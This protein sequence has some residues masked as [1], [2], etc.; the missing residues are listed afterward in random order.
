M[1]Y[2]IKLFFATA[3]IAVTSIT[4]QG[5]I[6]QD[7]SVFEINKMEPRATAIPYPDKKS[8]IANNPEKNSSYRSLNGEWKFSWYESVYDAPED[9][10]T[11]NYND[12]KWGHI[13]VPGNWEVNGYG[14]PIYVNQPYAFTS[15][16]KPPHI[17]DSINNTGLYREWIDIPDEWN[18]KTVILHIGAVKS[19]AFI[20]I[21]GTEV[22]YTQGAK[23]PSEFDIT[24]YIKPGKNLLAM[25]V[26]RWSDGSYLECQDFWR[27]SGIQR[28]VYLTAHNEIF[29]KDFHV[30][31]VLDEALSKSTIHLTVETETTEKYE[32]ITA[33]YQLLDEK[34]ATV[35]EKEIEITKDSITSSIS[36]DNPKLWSAEKPNL[37][38]SVI[39]LKKRNKILESVACNTGFRDVRIENG[40]LLV[41]R[42]PVYLKGV[43]RHEHDPV[44]AHY[45]SK[46]SMLVDIQLMKNHNINA[47][48]TC[49]Y[50]DDPY[51]YE[52][53]DKYG[54]YLIDEANIESHGMGYHPDRTLGNN[55][56]WEAAHMMRIRRMVER[57]KNHPSI[58]IWSLG[59]EAGDGCNFEKASAWVHERDNTRP[60]Q[61]ERALLRE[62]TDIYCPMYTSIKYIES[63]AQTD[64][65]RPLIMCEYAHSMGNSTGNLQDYWDVIEKYPR[66]QGGFIWDWVDQGLMKKDESGRSFWAYGGDFGPEDIPSD[67]NFCM[68]GLVSPTRTPHP[69]LYEV[70]KVYQYVDMSWDKKKDNSVLIKNKYHFTDLEDFYLSYKIKGNGIVLFEGEIDNISSLPGEYIS[71]TFPEIKKIA[72][73][74]N[75]KYFLH[76]KI[77]TKHQNGLLKANTTVASEQLR[78]PLNTP[79][80][81]PAMPVNAI[82]IKENDTAFILNASE[83]SYYI[84]KSNGYLEQIV[85]GG[86]EILASPLQPDFWRAPTDNDFGYGME[87]R[88]AI[89]K[90]ISRASSLNNIN[91]ENKSTRLVTLK[92]T[93]DHIDSQSEIIITYKLYHDGILAVLLE[94][95]P[96]IMGLPILPRFGMSTSLKRGYENLDWFGRGSHEN[97]IDRNSSAYID[98]YQSNVNNQFYP[99]S[100]PQESGNKSDVDWVSISDMTSYGVIFAASETLGFSALP[101]STS[102]L[103]CITKYN[104]RHPKDL[105]KTGITYLHI[106]K[107]QMGVGGD[108]SWGAMPHEKYRIEAEKM[109]FLFFIKPVDLKE[110][111]PFR[112]KKNREL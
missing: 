26:L 31:P 39:T 16:P 25:K 47:V 12:E 34:N 102:E 110:D 95:T 65:P 107:K 51:W 67:G 84:D 17:P 111:N 73:T 21:N 45:I 52:L 66:L 1:N 4:A 74:P 55:P 86:R 88:C 78:I 59:N 99:Y 32:D 8:A 93:I 94:F 72:P 48:R 36:F 89:W 43:N 63:W 96:C 83:I 42:V 6:W 50:P 29:I 15:D 20:Y 53:C 104:Y 33:V 41:N 5:Q 109:D 75:T 27:I 100:R 64:D 56:D 30:N 49:H 35:L 112:I 101:Y 22:G 91:I 23:L 76:L 70:Q 77:N 3:I 103:D 98:L 11:L 7:P 9:F 90:N 69:A 19:A 61:Y 38:R 37:Y 62:H 81:M 2:F 57:D 85:E 18:K 46:E 13:A 28:D 44:T 54:I 97:Y 92:A 106:D 82:T 40:Q 68:N 14:I 87:K 80:F 71:V 24:D 79:P 58:I 108:N 10:Y 60:V 105:I